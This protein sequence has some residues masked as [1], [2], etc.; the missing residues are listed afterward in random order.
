M[1]MTDEA[2]KAAKP[3]LVD[4][5]IVYMDL[6]GF[7]SAITEPT[8]KVQTLILETLREF[9]AAEQTFEIKIETTGLGQHTRM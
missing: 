1:A 9:K 7:G 5:L 4:H 3:L 6:L 2:T 8:E